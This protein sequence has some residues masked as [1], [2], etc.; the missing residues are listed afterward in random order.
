MTRKFPVPGIEQFAIGLKHVEEAVAIRD[1]IL[2]SFDRAANLPPGPERTRLLTVV[3]V[4]GGFTGVEGFGETL[5][6]AT[7]LLDSYP[8]LAP[9]DLHFHLVE[10][11]DRI[12]PEVS[13]RPGAWVVRSLRERGAPGASEHLGGL[14]R[15]RP[16]RAFRRRGVRCRADRLDRR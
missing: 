10:A 12:L 9:N 15:E 13:A 2:V 11:R 4:G 5:S 6:L 14:G 7:A 3:F 1:R 8:E 16:C